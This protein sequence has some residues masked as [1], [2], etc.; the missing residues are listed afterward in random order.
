MSCT[1]RR[2]GV[3]KC[4]AAAEAAWMAL[5]L[6][7]AGSGCRH[8][9]QVGN[10]ESHRKEHATCDRWAHGRTSRWSS[11]AKDSRQTGH[12]SSSN[13]AHLA[14]TAILGSA[15]STSRAGCWGR[16]CFSPGQAR[17][18]SESS[19]PRPSFTC[20]CKSSRRPKPHGIVPLRSELGLCTSEHTFLPLRTAVR[21]PTVVYERTARIYIRLLVTE[22][23]PRT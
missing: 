2:C 18:A 12:V 5:S 10:W 20:S 7:A 3:L 13:E 11:I 8:V 16:L 1:A 4:R 19:D 21:T 6:A 23:R 17:E 14:D 9:G 15:S 22:S